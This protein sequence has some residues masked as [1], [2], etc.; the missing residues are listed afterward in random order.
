MVLDKRPVEIAYA[1]MQNDDDHLG[2]VP[3]EIGDRLYATRTALG[4][5]Q[6]A[7]AERLG[8]SQPTYALYETGRRMLPPKWAVAVA[9]HCRVTTD[10][11]YLGDAS[12]IPYKLHDAIMQAVDSRKTNQ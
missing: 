5:T 11:L 7:F 8:L 10:W 12:G 2:P 4:L 1:E 3:S 9:V 6:A